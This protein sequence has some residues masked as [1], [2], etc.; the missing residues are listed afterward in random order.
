MNPL[1]PTKMKVAAEFARGH[2][3]AVLDPTTK[4][5]DIFVPKFWCHFAGKLK[6]YDLIEVV[7]QGFD[8]TVRVMDVGNGYAEVV[9][10]PYVNETMAEPTVSA[11]VA[12][13]EAAI[14]DG[15]VVDHTPKTLWR[16]R[17][18]DGGIEISRNHKTKLEAIGEAMKHFNK[19]MGVAA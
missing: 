18:K 8:V 9:A 7:G 16:A 12:A 2:H 5:E 13:L 1:H 4:Y 6:K 14:P 19:S 10:R 17:L 15:Y 3:F 11:E